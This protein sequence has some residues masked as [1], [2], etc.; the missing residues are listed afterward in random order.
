M[1]CEKVI[2]FFLTNFF[3]V[4]TIETTLKPGIPLIEI[5][6]NKYIISYCH[7]EG[8]G[9]NTSDGYKIYFK[10]LTRTNWNGWKSKTKT[11]TF[12]II[13]ILEAT[14]QSQM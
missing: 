5:K 2:V 14:I 11:N 4:A 7:D 12:P 6:T 8:H 10:H 3:S 1:I 9:Y 13:I